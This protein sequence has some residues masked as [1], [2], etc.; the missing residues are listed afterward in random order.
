MLDAS[1]RDA[2]TVLAWSDL[3]QKKYTQSESH[4]NALW[5]ADPQNRDYALGL[6]YS[7]LNLGRYRPSPR[8]VGAGG[9]TDDSRTLELKSLVYKA[10]AQQAYAQQ[11]WQVAGDN[12]AAAIKIDPQDTDSKS[13]LA[14]TRYQQN[15]REEALTLMESVYAQEKSP[16]AAGALLDFYESVLKPGTAG[17]WRMKWPEARITAAVKKQPI[18]FSPI[19]P[20]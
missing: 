18:S 2:R 13:L 9:I 3:D 1:D 20:P 15:R 6:G 11:D 10:R 5:V 17:A 14:W 7:R 16:A 8:T 12:L 19:A 4:F